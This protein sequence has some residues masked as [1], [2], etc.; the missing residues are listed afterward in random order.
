MMREDIYGAHDAFF[1]L[2]FFLHLM[3]G[4][5]VPFQGGNCHLFV[6]NLAFS[7]HIVFPYQMGPHEIFV[8]LFVANKALF[9]ILWNL[10]EILAAV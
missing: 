1:S 2:S 7:F 6:A 9:M 3:F 8:E 4:F 5:H 10:M